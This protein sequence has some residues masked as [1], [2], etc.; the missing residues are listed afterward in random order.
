MSKHQ[1]LSMDDIQE[2]TTLERLAEEQAKFCGVFSN[3]RRIMILWV[4]ADRELSAGAIAEAVCSSP[5]NVSQ[6]LSK[7]K[8]F[9]IVTS[10]REGQTIFYRV[11]ERALAGHCLGLSR[12]YL[13]RI[14]EKNQ[15]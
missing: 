1:V 3:T 15:G 7:M 10:R 9:N 11:D 12:A 5:Q 8:D 6:H 14:I 4:L 13:S 2:E